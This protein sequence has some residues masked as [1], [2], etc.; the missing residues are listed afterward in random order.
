MA[1]PSSHSRH[2]TLREV[3]TTNFQPIPVLST[4]RAGT[5]RMDDEVIPQ[6]EQNN[7]Q[8]GKYQNLKEK[9]YKKRCSMCLSE[10]LFGTDEYFKHLKEHYPVLFKCKVCQL[11]FEAWRD[12]LRHVAKHHSANLAQVENH[13]SLPGGAERMLLAKCKLRRCRRQF[14]ALTGDEVEQHFLMEHW[15]SRKK[16]AMALEWSCRV[17]NNGGRRFRG[18]EEAMRH[19]EMHLA[20]LIVSAKD[21]ESDSDTSSGGF[22]SGD[23]CLTSEDGESELSSVSERGTDDSDL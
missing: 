6:V 5:R 16:V 22:S 21:L 7:N 8:A 15:G 11:G 19:A 20:G 17:C 18:W 14:V 23:D 13:V 2:P 12:V 9:N 10:K 3:N 4:D 1:F